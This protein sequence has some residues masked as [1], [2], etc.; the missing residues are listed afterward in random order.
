MEPDYISIDRDITKD[1]IYNLLQ[2]SKDKDISKSSIEMLVTLSLVD[3]SYR[4]TLNLKKLLN[5]LT[6][7]S[8]SADILQDGL[9][10]SE[11][12]MLVEL[13]RKYL[14]DEARLTARC[15]L[16]V[17]ERWLLRKSVNGLFSTARLSG[18]FLDV[19]AQHV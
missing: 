4:L 17:K 11:T 12:V 1:D 19:G 6:E 15:L 14:S 2:E 9:T 8:V 10:Q 7:R 3:P 18:A 13:D 16:N 5:I